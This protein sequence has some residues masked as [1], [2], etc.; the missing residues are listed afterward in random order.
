MPLFDFKCKK[1][2]HKTYDILITQKHP[3]VLQKCGCGSTEFE[4]LPPKTHA[5]F[6][7]DGWTNP[8]KPEQE[9]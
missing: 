7:G 2:G 6:K 5:Q 1:C 9:E 4:K 3:Q 8:V